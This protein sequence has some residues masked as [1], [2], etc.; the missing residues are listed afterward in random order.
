MSRRDISTP[1]VENN[2]RYLFSPIED[3]ANGPLAKGPPSAPAA[4]VLV[5][6][7]EML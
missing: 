2:H 6:G 3:L 4:A 5:A 1:H 7:R